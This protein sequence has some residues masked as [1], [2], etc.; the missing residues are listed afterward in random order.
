MSDPRRRWD[1]TFLDFEWLECR[2][3]P[4]TVHPD[5][6]LHRLVEPTSASL[7]TN[8]NDNIAALPAEY[9]AESASEHQ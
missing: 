6:L 5:F 2:A 4:S 9:Q 8:A 7:A 1:K 3:L